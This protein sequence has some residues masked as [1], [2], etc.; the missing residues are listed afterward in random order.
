MNSAVKEVSL[1]SETERRYLS[2][3]LSVITSRALPDIRDGLKP[4]QRRILFAM[5][6]HLKLLPQSRFRKSATI[7]GE[8]MG[9]Y[10]PHGDQAIYD[11]MVR[12]AQPFSLLHPLIEGYG[13]FGSIDGDRAAAMRYTEARLQPISLELLDE[14]DQNTVHFK[15]NFDG[16]LKEPIVLPAKFPNLLVNGSSGIA[17]GMATNIPPHNLREVID[18][19]LLYLQDSEVPTA[20]LLTKL[21]GPDFPTGG[22]IQATKKELENIYQTGQGSFT[23]RGQWKPLKEGKKIKYI[24]ITSIPYG[25][26]RSTIV[27][28]IADIILEKKHPAILDVRDESTEDTRIIVEIKSNADPEKIMAYL[29]KHTPLQQK[30]SVN[31]T[32]LIPTENP[33]VCTPKRVSLKEIFHHFTQFRLDVIKRRLQDELNKI[34]SKLEIL[35]GFETVFSDLDRAV[36]T[37]RK[38]D[39]R[40]EVIAQLKEKF[41]LTDRQAEAIADI[42]L[43][44]LS[45]GEIGEIRNQLRQL[46]WRADDIEAILS[47]RRLLLRELRRELELIAEKYPQPRKTKISSRAKQIQLSAEDTIPDEKTHI[48]VT[49]DGWV[50]R[51]RSFGSIDSIRVRDGDSILTVIAGRTKDTVC[52]FS[53]RGGAYSIRAW[54]LPSTSGYG[55]PL[56]SLFKFKDGEKVIAAFIIPPTSQLSPTLSSDKIQSNTGNILKSEIEKSEPSSLLFPTPSTS[57]DSLQPAIF[58]SEEGD[59]HESDGKTDENGQFVGPFPHLLAVTRGGLGLRSS[60]ENFAQPSTKNGRRYIR[61]TEGDRVLYVAKIDGTEMLAL[62][63]AKGRALVFPAAEVKFVTSTAK[64]VKLIQ[65]ESGDQLFAAKTLKGDETSLRLESTGGKEFEISP[66][67]V[68][69]SRRGGKGKKLRGVS[70]WKKVIILKEELIQNGGENSTSQKAKGAQTNGEA[71]PSERSNAAAGDSPPPG[72]LSETNGGDSPHSF[73]TT[74]RFESPE[75][76]G[77]EPQK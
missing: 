55:T 25:T 13:N 57:N 53:D 2:Y 75:G 3:A 14:I 9:K 35:K 7:V 19:L 16:S 22:E 63:T 12:M 52:F 41:K 49:K 39:G 15:D 23:L 61:L 66:T 37:V 77:S 10:H 74:D 21:K 47:S 18:A 54:E 26:N 69:P 45:K 17:V 6:R 38:A 48:I 56:Q 59:K 33:Q 8:V 65:L 34:N 29:Y 44:K 62:A 42:K 50:K 5:Y 46:R 1:R 72:Q 70:G 32:C 73:D 24:A 68:K 20:K 11:A 40:A 76:K 71:E 43:Y 60:L 58:S 27:E 4:V 31:L 51:L 28:K 67:S 30:Y 36:E 64:G